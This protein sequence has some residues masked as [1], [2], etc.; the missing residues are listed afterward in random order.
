MAR[1][2]FS[3]AGYAYPD[4]PLVLQEVELNLSPGWTAI[5]GPNG[6]GKTTLLRLAAGE[7]AP[8]TGSVSLEPADARVAWCRQAPAAPTPEVTAFA[9]DWDGAAR[10][11]RARLDLDPDALARWATLSPGERQRWQVAAALSAE[12][13][14]LLLDEPTN[15][16]DADARRALIEMLRSFRGLGL[17]VAHDRAFLDALADRTVWV[18]G[19]RATKRAGTYGQARAA[20]ESEAERAGRERRQKKRAL[21]RM[22]DELDA[23]RR[24]SASAEADISARR[25]MKGPKDH[26]GR[27]ALAKGMAERAAAALSRSSAQLA[28]RVERAAV[29]LE[30][31]REPKELGGA[32]FVD[33]V[34]APNGTLLRAELD[35]RRIGDRVLWERRSVVVERTSR[36]RITG[37][38]GAGKSTLLRAVT[39]LWRLPR[40][41]LLHLPQELG[42]DARV[43]V[44]ERVRALPPDVRGRTLSL[45]AALGVDPKRLLASKRAS[46]GEARKLWLAEGL[47][48]QVWCVVLDEPTNHLDVPSIERLE[49]A[50]RAYPGALLLVTHDERLAERTTDVVW[51]FE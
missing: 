36:I 6:A 23:R 2:L 25:R 41:R 30:S 29:S 42:D 12:P 24:R 11:L 32:L 46:P 35:A 33:W 44:L 7:L 38:N 8:T 3:G 20:M 43:E 16:L 48:R 40:E 34:P 21:R 9:R 22:Q 19:G 47:G 1:I 31:A 26:D 14:V 50:L 15:H 49:A 18:E 4:A 5:A 51:S 28:G 10:K 17:V 39:G 37:P 13:E 45:V 27:G